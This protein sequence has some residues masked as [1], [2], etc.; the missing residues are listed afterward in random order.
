MVKWLQFLQSALLNLIVVVSL[1]ALVGVTVKELFRRPVIIE[2]I[3]LPEA[4]SK[5]G[6]TGVVTAHRLWDA[7][8]E[9]QD[10]SG[11]IKPRTSLITSA[12]QL[13]VV[14]PGTGLSLQSLTQVLRALF[15]LTQTR[16]SGEIICAAD[17]C[18]TENLQLRLRV[19]SGAGTR[20]VSAGV[21]GETPIPDYFLNSALAVLRVVDP[22]VVASYLYEDEVTRPDAIA[23]AKDMLRDRHP[24]RA[25]AANLLGKLEYDRGNPDAAIEWYRKSIAIAKTA[26]PKHWALPW[27][28]WGTGL[29]DL[30]RHEEAIAKYR[31]ATELD[32][33]DASPWYNW[34]TGLGDLGRHE[35]A[36]AKY[37]RATELDPEDASLW[38]NWGN[39]LGG[40]GRHEEAIAKYRRATEIDPE[41]AHPWHNWA[42]TLSQFATSTPPPDCARLRSLW[43]SYLDAAGDHAPDWVPARFA[44]QTADCPAPD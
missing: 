36:I 5:R 27:N 21:V 11:T 35:E 22:Y 13:N 42:V 7:M 24:Q 6:L 26:G 44:R 28:G 29:G 19:F 1:L 25:W 33:E 34:G 8:V 10:G 20:I 38:Y 12:R 43:Q 15:G 9:V 30:G 16:I 40:L 14:E 31:R 37:R 41:F 2:E 39:S 23:L 3:G 32:P 17:D 4:L 18:A